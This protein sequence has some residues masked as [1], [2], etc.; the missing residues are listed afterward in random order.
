MA[1]CELKY[2]SKAL[3]KATAADL[4]LPDAGVPGPFATLYLLHGLSD[5]HTIWQRR[6]SLERYVEN[7]PLIVVLPDGG[8]GFY[9]DAVE[10]PAGETAIVGDLVPY[11]DTLFHTRTSNTGRV[12]AGL[13]MGGYGAVSLALKHPELFGAAVSHSGA[14]AFAHRPFSSDDNTWNKEFAR[15]IGPN[16]VGGPN[17]LF[18]LTKRLPSAQRPAL[19]I[20]CGTEDFLLQD[21]RDFHTHLNAIEYPHEYAEHPGEHNWN[22]WNVRILDTLQFLSKFLGFPFNPAIHL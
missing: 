4:I 17:D 10:G 8:R 13:S 18:A 6:T 2:Y 1:F 21:N 15:I 3:G 16:P 9:C 11:V 20:D 19:R 22:Y 12:I 5:D 14:M 7:L